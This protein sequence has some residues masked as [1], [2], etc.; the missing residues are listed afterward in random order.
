MSKQRLS[1][2]Q[3]FI[4]LKGYQDC[5]V[6][7]RHFLEYYGLYSPVTKHCKALGDSNRVT[8]S[9]CKKHMLQNDLIKVEKNSKLIVLTK[10]GVN[11]LKT[12]NCHVS[13]T[14]VNF[15]DYSKRLE[16]CLNEYKQYREQVRIV[17]QGLKKR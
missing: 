2:L 4:L 1:K 13:V 7:R 15:N 16:Q 12:A 8:M 6:M 14:N 17:A 11:T 3:S 5:G 10:K 9:R